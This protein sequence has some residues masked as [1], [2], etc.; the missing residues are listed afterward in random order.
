[1]KNTAAMSYA[2]FLNFVDKS[3]LC[4]VA[5]STRAIHGWAKARY[6]MSTLWY[7]YERQKMQNKKAA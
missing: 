7:L 5:K 1:M 4:A 3:D 6:K 2:N